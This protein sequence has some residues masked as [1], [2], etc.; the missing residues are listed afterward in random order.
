MKKGYNFVD[1]QNISVETNNPYSLEF[2][3]YNIES[4]QSGNNI[5]E[6]LSDKNYVLGIGSEP[7]DSDIFSDQTS[8]SND[9]DIIY[10]SSDENIIHKYHKNIHKNIHKMLIKMLID[11]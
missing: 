1:L 2:H 6:H 9:S 10:S 3:K 4:Q 8:I 5:Y 11:D 7:T